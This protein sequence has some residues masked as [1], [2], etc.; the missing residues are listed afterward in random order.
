MFS[1]FKN[2]NAP[3]LYTNLISVTS[4]Y[5]SDNLKQTKNNT[6]KYI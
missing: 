3:N 4:P 1:I 6:I 2:N 5:Y